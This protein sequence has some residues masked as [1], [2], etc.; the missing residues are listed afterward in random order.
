[1]AGS[2]VLNPSLPLYATSLKPAL[3][4]S[5][6]NEVYSADAIK[7]LTNS[8]DYLS[9]SQILNRN[10]QAIADLAHA[11]SLSHRGQGPPV[12]VRRVLY[13][14]Y[15]STLANYQAYMC[16]SAGD[17]K[18]AE[19]IFE[20]GY[21]CLLSI[22]FVDKPT[23]IA[24]FDNLHVH[25]GPHLGAHLTLALPYNEMVWGSPEIVEEGY[26]AGYGL[27]LEQVRIS[28]GLEDV[29]ELLAVHRHAFEAAAATTTSTSV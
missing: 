22:E 14:P 9:R 2:V 24:F 5:H 18:R 4:K 20:P 23:A 13:P 28:V 1:M 29:E 12:L 26:H 15:T 6:R 17:G 10:A 11:Y 3:L 7:L 8:A 19:E 16:Q 21:G 25:K 27:G